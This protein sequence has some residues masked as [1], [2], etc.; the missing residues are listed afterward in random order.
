[1]SG[2]AEQRKKDREEMAEIRQRRHLSEQMGL[3]HPSLADPSPGPDFQSYTLG[4]FRD[5]SKTAKTQ[6]DSIHELSEWLKTLSERVTLTNLR[7]DALDQGVLPPS[8]D[9]LEVPDERH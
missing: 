8:G 7:I 6:L 5:I 9:L 2:G 1:M 4:L 3:I